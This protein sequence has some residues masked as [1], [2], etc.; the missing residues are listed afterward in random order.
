MD[1]FLQDVRYGIRM[2]LKNPGFT[3]V[4]VLTLALG[5][6]ANTAIFTVVNAVLLRQMPYP[7]PERLMGVYH[8]YP[9]INLLRASV[10]AGSWDYYRRNA[11]S[12]E[13]MTAFSGF[14]APQ[15]LTGVGDPQR[16]RTL[17]VSGDFFRVFGVPPMLGR[18]LPKQDDAPGSREAGLGY[19]L[20]K[21]RFGSDRNI[22]GKE[23]SLNGM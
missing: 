22:L 6:G 8:S 19:G 12:F 10:D 9:S 17:T 13:T 2:L 15:N 21:E 14:K 18:T 5:I 3:A 4:A 11:K 20:W 7:H 1:N 23:V 16:V